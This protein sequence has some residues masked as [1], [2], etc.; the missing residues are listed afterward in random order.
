DDNIIEDENSGGMKQV[1][2]SGVEATF[3]FILRF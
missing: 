1:R 3:S 2:I